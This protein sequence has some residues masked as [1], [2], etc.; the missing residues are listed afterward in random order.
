MNKDPKIS[1]IQIRA[2]LVSTIIGIGVLSMY[3]QLANIMDK[4]GWIAIILSGLLVVLMLIIISKIFQ[5]NPGKDFFEIGNET[6][7]KFAFSIILCIYVVYYIV[8]NAYISRQLGELIKGFLLPNTPI[9]LIIVLFLLSISYAAASEIDVIARVT[10][11]MYP[12]IIIFT[13]VL[14][15][16]SL[17]GA[18]ITNVLPVFQSD[19]SKLPEGV[20]VALFS[21]SGFE[22]TLF[23]F[24]F[25]EDKKKLT[26]TCISAIAIITAIYLALFM[27][28]LSQFSIEQIKSDPFPLLMV[29]KLIDLPGYFLQNL[30]GLVMAI[31][32][33]LIFSTIT[34]FH[35]SAGKILSKIFKTKSHAILVL[36]L[37]P[38]IY[39]LAIIPRSII[40]LNSIM[41]GV[42]AYLSILVSVIVPVIIFI[43]GRI[44]G[45]KKQ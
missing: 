35:Y 27:V 10:Y 26:K 2:L 41:S 29:T 25:V 15:L 16:V 20:K 39:I 45:R 33:M 9:Q 38:V 44:R 21:F 30:D 7:G 5:G 43:V 32:V 22:V 11:M 23:A 13:I 18:D 37:V 17:P 34:P 42:I 8:V 31:W 1:S 40:E 24:P 12:V 6:L 4:D 36:M 19:L 28:T 3:N 14:F